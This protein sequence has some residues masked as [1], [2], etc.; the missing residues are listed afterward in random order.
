[1]LCQTRMT[2][3]LVVQKRCL[4]EWQLFF[5][6]I[7]C[8]KML[9][10]WKVVKTVSIVMFCLTSLILLHGWKSHRGLKHIVRSIL[11]PLCTWEM[12]CAVDCMHNES[13]C[14]R[15]AWD[16]TSNM[17]TSTVK[18]EKYL[19]NWGTSSLLLCSKVAAYACNSLKDCTPRLFLL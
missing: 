1:M 5:T 14:H 4:V 9:W 18:E 10:K 16:T 17:L 11:Y 19:V 2:L 7:V 8:N 12:Y 13:S 6:F 15:A 3:F